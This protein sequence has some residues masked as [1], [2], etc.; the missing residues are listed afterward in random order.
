MLW[1]SVLNEFNIDLAQPL[2]DDDWAFLSKHAMRIRT[3]YPPESFKDLFETSR[4]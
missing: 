3:L 4:T 2:S 1:D